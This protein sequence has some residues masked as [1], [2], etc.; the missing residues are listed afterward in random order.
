MKENKVDVGTA[1]QGRILS[2]DILRGMAVIVFAS[3]FEGSGGT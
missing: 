1:V 3:L 2:I